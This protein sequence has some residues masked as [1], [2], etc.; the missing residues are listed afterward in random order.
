MSGMDIATIRKGL[1][2][3][4]AE[5]AA[6]VGARE[7]Y[8]SHLETGFRRPSLK[9]AARIE[10]ATGAKGLVAAVVAEKLGDA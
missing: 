2:L 10:K 1:G 8:I 4:Q 3:S 6:K 9:L 7:S 5:F